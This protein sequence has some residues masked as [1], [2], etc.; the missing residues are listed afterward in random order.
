M[1][2]DGDADEQ[3]I[4]Q[5]LRDGTRV[6][7]RMVGPDDR[8]ELIAGFQRLSTRSRY[9]R[10]HA[11]VEHLTEQ[12]IRYLTDV[13]QVNH[14]AWVAVD[15]DAP[16]H[17]GIGVARFVRLHDEPTVAEAAVTV[18][19]DYQGRGLGTELLDVL[20]VAAV[21][22]GVTTFRAYVLGENRA[23]LAMLERLGPTHTQQQRGVLQI[24]VE[25]PASEVDT[26]LAAREVF[27]AVTRKDV[28][29]MVT[30]APPVWLSDDADDADGAGRQRL[31]EWLDR[32]LDR[33]FKSDPPDA[34]S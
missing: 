34:S 32:T 7:I 5:R 29:P 30:I 24:D 16:D 9:L 3:A 6:L 31:R 11:N 10:F 2:I 1:T 18:L 25:L 27:H 26:T 13:D 19:D 23:M 22:R 20:A 33:R 15:L 8:D 17:P 14:V 21:R 12:Q 4:E 28:P